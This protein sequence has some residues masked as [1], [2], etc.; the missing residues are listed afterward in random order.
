VSGIDHSR[1]HA[2][3]V[4]Y[5]DVRRQLA[6]DGAQCAPSKP[7]IWPRCTIHGAR[8][9]RG[10]VPGPLEPS[11]DAMEVEILDALAT[12][13]FALRRSTPQS[14]LRSLRELDAAAIVLRDLADGRAERK[15]R[16]SGWGW[17]DALFS[18]IS[19]AN[20]TAI[21]QQS[22]AVQRTD[23]PRDTGCARNWAAR[24]TLFSALLRR[25]P[26]DATQAGQRLSRR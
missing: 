14:R 13:I 16:A 11:S 26:L 19:R 10:L 24:G 12:I 25:I 5:D 23:D 20:R 9:P 1:P 4:A 21:R 6:A 3:D 18:K 17:R 8:H 7:A 22:T 2:Q 15:T